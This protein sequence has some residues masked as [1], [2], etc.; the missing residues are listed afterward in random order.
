MNKH[1]LND[2]A[3]HSYLRVG[4]NVA[5]C[6]VGIFFW[7]A[8]ASVSDKELR[9]IF[10]LFGLFSLLFGTALLFFWLRWSYHAVQIVREKRGGSVQIELFRKSDMDSTT[11]YANLCRET[12][13]NHIQVAL[14]SPRWKY[15]AYLGRSLPGIVYFDP[16]RRNPVAV[17]I[18][19]KLVWCIPNNQKVSL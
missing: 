3:R 11:L 19:E 2:L 8:A 12:S 13:N 6:V 9:M 14:L 17:M 5:L 10:Q 15:D 16:I 1:F 18:D 4:A 7:Q